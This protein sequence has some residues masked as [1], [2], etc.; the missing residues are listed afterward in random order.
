MNTEQRM[1]ALD[2]A[3]EIRIERAKLKLRVKAGEVQPW[4]LILDPPACI[5]GVDSFAFCSWLPRTARQ[6]TTTVL[7]KAGVPSHRL[8]GSLTQNQRER[9]SSAIHDHLHRET[10]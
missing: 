7:R 9:L 2:L 4:R 10:A 3:N 6:R 8:V 5:T 1:A